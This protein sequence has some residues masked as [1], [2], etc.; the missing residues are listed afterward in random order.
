MRTRCLHLCSSATLALA[1]S[2]SDRNPVEP[3]GTEG[4]AFI[5]SDPVQDE[6]VYVSLSP[7]TVPGGMAGTIINQT[8]GGT[9]YAFLTAGGFDPV[10]V[11]AR[12][13]DA[14]E[15]EV[16][17]IDGRGLVRSVGTVPTRRPPN[18]VRASPASTQLGVPLNP[19]IVIVF[20]EPIQPATLT[21]AGVRLT[22]GTG[23]VSGQITLDASGTRAEFVPDEPLE[24]A[25]T[26][27]LALTRDI[28]DLGGDELEA[29]SFAFTTAGT[30]SLMS[31]IAF[32]G[33]TAEAF[34]TCGIWVVN[35]DGSDRRRLSPALDSLDYDF[36]P[37]WSPDGD[38]IAFASY[39]H[40][41]PSGRRPIILSG[42]DC[43]SEI[44]TMYSDGFGIA[45]LTTLEASYNLGADFPAWAPSGDAITF[46]L[47][48]AAPSSNCG[49][50]RANL[51]GSGAM[52]VIENASCT[53]NR[54]SWS[55]DGTRMAFSSPNNE[56]PGIYVANADG[57]NLVR[58][59]TTRDAFPSWSPDGT[60]IAFQRRSASATTGWS[61]RVMA[62]DGGSET[63]VTPD[64]G[65]LHLGPAWS[66]DGNKIVFT[67]DPGTG[68]GARELRI[69]NADGSG[70]TVLIPS[71]QFQN[72]SLPA[73]SPLGSVP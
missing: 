66:P 63:Q 72:L 35:A 31:Q 7:G 13:G 44:Y 32:S 37:G 17:G 73:W 55:P 68:P 61:I 10:I 29:E 30:A 26:Y 67:F 3:A 28:A 20:S 58:L 34:G 1:A 15:L 45:R 41:L 19:R 4:P 69:T 39:R 54:P 70:V 60:R 25:T 2:C 64:N 5:V 43:P 22:A 57:S 12:A 56:S 23:A 46:V 18:I 51:N 9:T 38:R 36:S 8:R 48:R 42:G 33:C 49:I 14:L 50:Y 27:M 6:R 47:W 16:W 62:S 40:C 59:T 21:T 71:Q 52:K 65:E 11:P 53:N 24:A